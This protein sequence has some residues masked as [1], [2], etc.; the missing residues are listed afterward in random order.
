LR[1]LLTRLFRTDPSTFTGAFAA[2]SLTVG[3]SLLGPGKT[4]ELSPAWATL[5]AMHG[6]DKDWGAMMIA[7]GLLLLV[8]LRLQ[9]IPFRV[10][11]CLFSAIMWM[12][13]GISMVYNGYVRGGFISIVGVFSI[14]CSIQAWIAVDL[15]VY[16]M[17]PDQED[18]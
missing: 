13:L 7:D 4:F 2:W 17:P 6:T 18:S 14:W 12:L 3:T 11:I 5:Q 9:R 15:W 16:H 1:T 10:G 8:A